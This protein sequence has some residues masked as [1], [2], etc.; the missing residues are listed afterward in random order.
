MRVERIG[1]A[2][3]VRVG[4]RD[5]LVAAAAALGLRTGAPVLV[6][7]GGADT[8]ATD[9]EARMRAFMEV[10]VP[11][12][13]R[14]GA[15]V[16]DGGTATGVMRAVGEARR[17]A[18][19]RFPLVGVVVDALARRS[20]SDTGEGGATLEPAHT[21]FLLVP[22]EDWGDESTWLAEFAAVLAEEAASLTLLA[23]GGEV[24]WQD[25]A[26]SVELD[27]GVVALAGSGRAADELA[28]GSSPR[29][30]EL[31]ESGLIEAVEVDRPLEA[32]AA[33][34]GRLG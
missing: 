21:H 6:V 19:G 33:T 4:S 3:A 20:G 29:A 8:M 23:N 11:H 30:R 14:A 1:P 9:E 27:R 32:L 22:G 5:E 18:S 12:L 28:S 17:A 16:V 24:A 31:R 7:V 15:T 26:R 13:D 2:R 34:V 25:V 10:L